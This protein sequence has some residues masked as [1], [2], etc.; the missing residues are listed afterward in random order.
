MKQK[1]KILKL[2]GKDCDIVKL[3]GTK[4]SDFRRQNEIQKTVSKSFLKKK[5]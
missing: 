1:K 2:Y 4:L 3:K 5:I